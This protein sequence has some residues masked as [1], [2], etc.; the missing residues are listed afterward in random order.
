MVRGGMR[1]I[2]HRVARGRS[3]ESLGGMRTVRGES[4]RIRRAWELC[5]VPG[6]GSS[7]TAV[8]FSRE[9]AKES[10]RGRKPTVSIDRVAAPVGATPTFVPS[11]VLLGAAWFNGLVF[12]R[13]LAPPG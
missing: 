1:A 13:G 12:L 8:Q 3:R 5:A 4:D 10:S 7:D 6:A 9:A 2:S 11:V